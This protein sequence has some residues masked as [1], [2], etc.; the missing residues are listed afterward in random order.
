MVLVLVIVVVIGLAGAALLTFSDTSIRTTVALRDQAAAAYAADGAGQVAVAEL[1]GG[2][3][4]G[5]C[6]TVAGDPLPLGNG[7]TA[8]YTAPH[9][10]ATSLNASP[11]RRTRQRAPG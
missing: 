11:A 2:T 10:G 7:T 4:P 9:N 3:Y 1:A 6:A 5:N 8:F